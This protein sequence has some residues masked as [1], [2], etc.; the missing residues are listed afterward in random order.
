MKVTKTELSDCLIIEPKVFGDARGFFYESYQKDNYEIAGIA[1][2]FVQDNFSRSSKGIL[3]GLHSQLSKPQGKLVTVIRGEVFDVAVDL[4]L[5]SPTF[6][7]HM[8]IVL[9][10]DN[11]KQLY[12]PPGFGHGFFA[13]SD[14]VDFH[15][16]C[17][18]YY[19]PSDEVGINWNDKDLNIS[20][21]TNTPLLSN[22]DKNL[23]SFEEY[24]NLVKGK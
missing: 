9:S 19:D 10:E 24:K 7:Q 2:C 5:W 3:R 18:D 21:P 13:L 20:W 6:G 17:T 12:I 23:L 8:S 22:K 14:E 1:E 4:R 16:K 15:Y 11:H